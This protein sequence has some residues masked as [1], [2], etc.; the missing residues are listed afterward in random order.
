MIDGKPVDAVPSDVYGSPDTTGKEWMA[1]SSSMST[2]DGKI[3]FYVSSFTDLTGN[4]G[5]SSSAIS[6]R[7]D[8]KTGTDSKMILVD[9]TA[10]TNSIITDV[11]IETDNSLSRTDPTDMS[12]FTHLSKST[13]TLTVQFSTSEP[14]SS[15]EVMIDGKPVDAV[16]SDVY[17]SPDTTGKE[18]MASSSSMSTT[19]GKISFY[20]SSFTDLTGNEGTSSVAI[21][22]RSDDMTGTDSKMILVDDTAP[23]NSIITDVT[24]ETDNS[25]SRTDPTDMSGFTH[26][27][28]STDTLTVQFSTSEPLSS[29][30]VM[31]DGKP[32]DAVP[33][34]VYGSPDT[35]GKEWMASSSSMSTT[36]G[37]ISFYVSSF[38]DL[39]GNEGTSSSAISSRSDDMTGT[40]SKMILVDDTAPTNSIIT[41]VTIETDNSLSRTDPTDM[42]GFTS[43]SKSTDTL[44]VQ[45]RTSEPLSS[46]EC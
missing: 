18:W 15:A 29:A 11:T 5:T 31:I 12:G 33:S 41:D 42:S 23:T 45:F 35:T 14:L 32:V 6:S 13:D 25:L 10:P 7:S 40:D 24:I 2:T 26:L 27:S 1:S 36:D 28:K 4:E 16:P 8:D 20:V 3:S 37:K 46:A 43:L 44:T 30:E 22:S 9:D 21:S 39:T 19:D 34:D 17:G 38:T